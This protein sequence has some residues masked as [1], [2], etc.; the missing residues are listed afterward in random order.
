MKFGTRLGLA[1]GGANTN[2]G[3]VGSDERSLLKFVAVRLQHGKADAD[4]FGCGKSDKPNDPA[5]RKAF[6][7]S[8]FAEVFNSF[9]QAQYIKGNNDSIFFEGLSENR[10][11]AGVGLVAA[12]PKGIVAF[13]EQCGFDT[14]PN[15]GV[16]QDFHGSA[17]VSGSMRS[18]LMRR[19]A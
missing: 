17:I 13:G 9:R 3:T 1:V 11:I 18:W 5:V 12:C 6:D 16:D 8:Q 14:A 10:F 2:A 19:W 7:D 15:A 4:L